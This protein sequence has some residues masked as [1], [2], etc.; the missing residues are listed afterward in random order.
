EL[1]AVARLPHGGGGDDRDPLR[2]Q[3]ARVAHL[4]LDDARHLGELLG[5]DRAAAAYGPAEAGEDA[6]CHQLTQRSF[7]AFGE[8]EARG[9]RADVDAGA[10]H[11]RQSTIASSSAGRSSTL[12]SPRSTPARP[13]FFIR[14]C[15]PVS[16]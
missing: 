15:A 13:P 16:V 6:L 1:P 8:Q 7:A 4:L 14:T 5:R 10:R 9:V 2:A 3:L 11:Q 12:S